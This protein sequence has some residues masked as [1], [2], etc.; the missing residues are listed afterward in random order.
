MIWSFAE[1]AYLLLFYMIM[2]QQERKEPSSLNDPM[3]WSLVCLDCLPIWT[4]TRE[5][6]TSLI[7][8]TEYLGH[9]LIAAYL[10][11]ICYKVFYQV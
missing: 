7:W 10:N 8:V 1:K 6:E 2:E 11:I 5:K 3:E 9:F 4:I